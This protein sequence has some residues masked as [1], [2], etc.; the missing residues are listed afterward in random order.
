M[1]ETAFSHDEPRVARE[2][3]VGGPALAGALVSCGVAG[4]LVLL[5]WE[6]GG[7]DA[8]TRYA[9]TIAVWWVLGLGVAVGLLPRSRLNPAAIAA[10]GL[11]AAYCA[12]TFASILWASSAERVLVEFDRD[13]MYLGVVAL[14]LTAVRASD[15][16]RIADGLAVGIAAVALLAFASRVYP[17]PFPT[18]GIPE[19]LAGSAN[20]LSFPLGYWNGL[21][22]LM[23]L[24]V[25]LLL[26]G[27]L[28]WR[29]SIARGAAI[30]MLPLLGGVTYLCSS[31]GGVATAAMA[32]G[33]FVVLSKDRWPVVGAVTVGALGA[34]AAIVV[35]HARPAFVNGP[36]GTATD[37]GN[38]A[39]VLILLICI[40]T[41]V[42]LALVSRAL[43]GRVTIPRAFG[44]AAAVAAVGLL[45][46]GAIAA[47]PV[48]R[49]DAFKALPTPG[50]YT[51]GDFV[52][53]HLLDG[54]GT[55]RW[56]QWSVAVDAWRSAPVRGIGAGGFEEYWAQHRPLDLFVKDA[57]SL[58]VEALG[59]LGIIGFLLLGGLLAL[60]AVAGAIRCFRSTAAERSSRAAL[61]AS[62]CAFLVAAGIDW[63]WEL[64]VVGI[65]GLAVLA[66]GPTQDG[67]PRPMPVGRRILATAVAVFVV[68]ASA[69]L[70]VTELDLEASRHA[71][72]S[73]KPADAL[74]Y[75]QSAQRLAPWAATPRL[76]IA[77]VRERVGEL[78]SARRAIESATRLDPQDWTLWLVRARIETKAGAVQSAAASLRRAAALNP[79]SPLF[80]AARPP[81][82]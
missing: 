44:I 59:E 80:A 41:G 76:Q 72:G 20:R 50:S 33:A 58:Y 4:L 70:L 7:Y 67:A 68:G 74:A 56:Q 52:N 6:N 10:L 61:L 19:F 81:G 37:Q 62:G 18:R 57:H 73:G 16:G 26:R 28:T 66:A 39:A 35:L 64:S 25:P 82:G 54:S 23:A 14:V 32:V 8:T 5:A 78:E 53:S 34:A 43:R 30:A 38:S 79:R 21:A 46:A 71:S 9:T 27:A 1:S 11:G 51:P 36:S 45:V 77:L 15:L 12:W 3:S 17:D 40:T 69:V 48:R 22:I 42:L 47:H 29:S 65:V 31:R 24:G 49:F 55:W 13:L 75:A 60:L 63:M 2:L